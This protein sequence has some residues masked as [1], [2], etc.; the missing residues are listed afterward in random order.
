ME[1]VSQIGRVLRETGTVRCKRGG[2]HRCQGY[3]VPKQTPF[4]H[5]ASSFAA[6]FVLHFLFCAGRSGLL[7]IS[8]GPCPHRNSAP[9]GIKFHSFTDR[10]RITT[11]SQSPT[12]IPLLIPQVFCIAICSFAGLTLRHPGLE[13]G[14]QQRPITSECAG[15]G[16]LR[17]MVSLADLEQLL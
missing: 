1:I 17:A 15:N 6:L 7:L 10:A 12:N 2:R 13:P 14:A 11:T 3:R 4:K 5:N 16:Y 8:Y 9:R